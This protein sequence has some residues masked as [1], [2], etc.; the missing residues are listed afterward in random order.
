MLRIGVVA[1]I[2]ALLCTVKGVPEQLKSR[3]Q[4][5]Q[6]DYINASVANAADVM[7]Q[8][9]TKAGGRNDTGVW[10]LPNFR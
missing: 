4:N 9:S 6:K 2:S 7:L 10:L 5:A 3:Q 8:I 1:T